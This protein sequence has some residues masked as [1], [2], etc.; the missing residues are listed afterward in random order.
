ML[1][2]LG[3]KAEAHDTIGIALPFPNR[4]EPKSDAA[5]V[6]LLGPLPDQRNDVSDHRGHHFLP[7]LGKVLRANLLGVDARNRRKPGRQH[8]FI[9]FT[10][11]QAVGLK[12]AGVGE[13][14]GLDALVESKHSEL[15]HSHGPPLR[16]LV[17]NVQA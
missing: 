11:A 8:L 16:E 6:S 3:E 1:A 2:E 9:A 7:T 4:N 17:L 14:H 10:F 15:V 5:S 13:E 12:E